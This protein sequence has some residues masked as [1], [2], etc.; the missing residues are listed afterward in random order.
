M[1]RE[2]GFPVDH[3]P[4]LSAQF[5]ELKY[6]EKQIGLAGKLA[7]SPLLGNSARDIW[8]MQQLAEA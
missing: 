8:E 2:M 5:Q 3:D 7:L 4:E 6:L 1:R